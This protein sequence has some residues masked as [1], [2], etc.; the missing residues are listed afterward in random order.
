MKFY[1][2]KRLFYLATFVKIHF[3]KTFILPY[4]DFCLS[5]IIYY[6]KYTFQSISN[7]F[8]LF[9]YR[10]FKF[11]SDIHYSEMENKRETMSEFLVK[12][13]YDLFTLQARI[14]ANLLTFAHSILLSEN[15]PD[16]LKKKLSADIAKNEPV[17][18]Q[19]QAFYEL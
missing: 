3:F 11:K 10:F 12:F 7:C 5:L 6:L 17:Q 1:S 15:A 8:N 19:V 18:A 4:F 13:K 16:I 9:H 14:Y 2:I